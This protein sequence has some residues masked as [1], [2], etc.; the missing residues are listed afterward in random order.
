MPVQ[1]LAPSELG[2]LLVDKSFDPALVVSAP[3]APTLATAGTG[4]TVLAGVYQQKISYVTALGESLASAVASI[5]TTGSLSTVT[6]PA[7]VSPPAAATGYYV[8]STQLGGTT[9]TRQQTAGS[10]TAIATP[11]VLTAPPTLTGSGTPGANL[12]GG[13]PFAYV[14][15]THQVLAETIG[16]KQTPN[17]AKRKTYGNNRDANRNQRNLKRKVGGPVGFPLYERAAMPLLIACTGGV[18]NLAAIASD[19]TT[20][21]DY[22]NP[23][24]PVLALT[25]GTGLWVVGRPVTVTSTAGTEPAQV[26]AWVS[27]PKKLS[28]SALNLNHPAAGTTVSSD[29]TNLIN[30]Y[31]R[32]SGIANLLRRICAEEILGD[33]FS[34]QFRAGQVDSYEFKVSGDTLQAT[35]DIKFDRPYVRPAVATAWNESDPNNDD[36]SYEATDIILAYNSD[37]ASTGTPILQSM[38]LSTDLNIKISNNLRESKRLDRQ[39]A[40]CYEPGDRLVTV[41]WNLLN[42]SNYPVMYE[43]FQDTDIAVSLLALFTHDFGTVGAPSFRSVGIYCPNVAL[44]TVDEDDTQGKTMGEMIKGEAKAAAGNES[45]YIY[46]SNGQTLT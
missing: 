32:T 17:R 8:Y 38:P 4:G 9:F 29:A 20:A 15:P 24:I 31:T 22:S 39:K 5:T 13:D 35:A 11:F 44:Q 12:S 10:P 45:I 3:T 16:F 34:R 23:N 19:T 1:G 6:T 14:Q 26:L 2:Y 25:T 33:K 28:L 46:V 18:A 42:E 21:I 43:A 37:P 41:D 30:P 40:V 7:P 27:G 36:P